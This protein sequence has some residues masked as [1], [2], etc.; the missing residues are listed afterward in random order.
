MR[1]GLGVLRLPSET[2]WRMTPRELKHAAD[3]VFGRVGAGPTRATLEALLRAYPD[4]GQELDDGPKNA[5][6]QHDT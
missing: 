3:G 2:F 5:G 4:V 6:V 1:L